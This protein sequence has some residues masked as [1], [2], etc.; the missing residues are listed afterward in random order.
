MNKI[1]SAI[2]KAQQSL[3]IIVKE[4]KKTQEELDKMSVTFNLPLD[5]YVR[6]QELKSLASVTNIIT[7]DEAQTIY[8]YL[9]ES[10]DTFNSQPLAVKLVLTKLFSE[11]LSFSF[12]Q[13]GT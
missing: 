9:G 13:K 7:L 12:S 1:T 11:L 6:F 10:P 4:G 2:A 8:E 3:E 5:E